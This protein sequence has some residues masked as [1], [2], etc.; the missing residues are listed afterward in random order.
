LLLAQAADA[1]AGQA[2]RKPNLDHAGKLALTDLDNRAVE[3]VAPN[4][5]AYRDLLLRHLLAPV[6]MEQTMDQPY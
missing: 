6:L 2:A 5:L 3:A 1:N 4:F